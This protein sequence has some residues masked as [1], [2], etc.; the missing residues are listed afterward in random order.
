MVS[1]PRLSFRES[2]FP[3]RSTGGILCSS[4]PSSEQTGPSNPYTHPSLNSPLSTNRYLCYELINHGFTIY[5]L[6]G[7]ELVDDCFS[8]SLPL[9]GS[10][11]NLETTWSGTSCQGEC[12]RRSKK[13]D[14]CCYGLSELPGTQTRFCRSPLSESRPVGSG[15]GSME[16][17]SGFSSLSLPS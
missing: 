9:L 8:S 7:N 13:R 2:S 11:T 12:S 16:S 6:N 5:P 10:E 3:Q 15:L 4:S 17:D 14:I 1:Y